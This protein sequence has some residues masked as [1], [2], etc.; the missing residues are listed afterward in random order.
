MLHP[1]RGL[2]LVLDTGGLNYC[3]QAAA[4]HFTMMRPSC[5]RSFS[6]QYI[7]FLKWWPFLQAD[8]G[9]FIEGSVLL[10]VCRLGLL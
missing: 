6:G 7:L 8:M 1:D 5:F 2:L 9:I 4:F 10:T 3:F